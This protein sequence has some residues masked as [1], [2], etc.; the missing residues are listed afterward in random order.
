MKRVVFGLG[1]VLGGLLVL[2]SVGVAIAQ[3]QDE[4]AVFFREDWAETPPSLPITR[5]HVA[6]P[7]L[8]LHLYGPGGDKVKK[9]HHEEPPLD[10]Y[11]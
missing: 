11:Y 2:A 4:G 7:D 8:T 9:S 6:N 10:P 5:E 1:S 3:A